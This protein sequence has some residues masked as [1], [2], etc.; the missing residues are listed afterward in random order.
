MKHRILLFIIFAVLGYCP[1]IKSQ[2]APYKHVFSATT[3]LRVYQFWDLIGERN[4]SP[5]AHSNPRPNPFYGLTYDY[6]TKNWFS[7]GAAASYHKYYTN[8]YIINEDYLDTTVYYDPMRLRN[9]ST[10]ITFRPLF[11]YLNEGRIDIY[12][13]FRLGVNIW[14]ASFNADEW[15]IPRDRPESKSG[16]GAIIQVIPLGIRGYI[17]PNWGIG[18]EACIG[19]IRNITGH[20]GGPGYFSAQLNYR[21]N[22]A[23][24]R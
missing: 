11:H 24:S 3:G 12:A 15:T 18:V 5:T 6:Y 9:T 19:G 10:T 4:T 1:T 14:S 17:T 7:I 21:L 20:I 13:G 16:V 8:V 22:T 23:S 2:N